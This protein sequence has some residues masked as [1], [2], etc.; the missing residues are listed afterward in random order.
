MDENLDNILL[1]RYAVPFVHGSVIKSDHLPN[2]DNERFKS[3]VRVDK[4]EFQLILNQIKDDP[5]LNNTGKHSLTEQLS[6]VLYK[7]GSSGEGASVRK[8]SNLFGMS[9]G[10]YIG[11]VTK[12]IFAV[13]LKK[14]KEYINWPN[15]EERGEI[16][17]TSMTE[18]PYCIG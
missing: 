18:L 17:K 4:K 11:N 1:L 13:I 10:G 7:L 15:K 12:K 5:L 9:D 14:R 2:L 16:V 3:M 6:T 8:I